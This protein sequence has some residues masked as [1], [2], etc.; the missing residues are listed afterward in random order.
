MTWQ[1]LLV[2][3]FERKARELSDVLDGL[4]SKDLDWRPERGANS[5]GWLAWHLTR[6]LDRN[7]SEIMGE[8]QLWI[9]DGWHERFDREPDPG[10]TGVGH[11]PL[12]QATAFRSPDGAVLM[13][14]HLAALDR[15]RQYAGARLT[16]AELERLAPS[17]TLGTNW[18][19]RRRLVGIV[20][21]G[22]QHV[23]QAAYVRG[24][25]K[26]AGWLGR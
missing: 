24:L 13:E 12:E 7:L 14:Y 3:I 22:L 2:D 4:T 19:V 6:S 10:E 18:T 8:E 21:D 1:G 5:I 9:S 11:G 15:L 16:E 26:G 17:P 23:G 20:N 25:L